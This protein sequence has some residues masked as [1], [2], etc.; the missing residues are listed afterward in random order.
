MSNYIMIII[1]DILFA[2]QFLFTRLYEQRNENGLTTSL[3]FSLG[4]N[5][6]ICLLML[7][8]LG[9]RVEFTWFSM[10]M[11]ALMACTSLALTYCSIASLSCINLSM[12]SV[13]MMLGGMLIPFLYGILFLG[14]GMTVGKAICVV[15]I[16]AAL[17]LGI[18]RSPQKKGAGKYYAGVFLLNGLFGVWSKL[19]Q[20]HPEMNTSTENVLFLSCGTVVVLA[21]VLLLTV[22]KRRFLPFKDGKSAA[23]MA[24]YGVAN[25]VAEALSLAAMI[26]LPAS[27]QFA[28]VTGGVM[29]VSAVISILCREKQ[30]VKSLL[31]MGLAVLAM[32]AVGF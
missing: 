17:L 4:A 15:L 9:F 28:L 32:I 1:A 16:F 21:L 8:L 5:A 20:I 27:I 30:S 24:G 10:G 19:H 7:C 12:Y 14:E 13:F 31:A 23:C 29:V 18:D 6:M 3:N 11:A 2:T 26:T 25:G 22:G